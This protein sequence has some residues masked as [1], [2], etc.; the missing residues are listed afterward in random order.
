ML[1]RHSDRIENNHKGDQRK[2]D[3]ENNRKLLNVSRNGMNPL[4]GFLRIGKCLGHNYF[5]VF[6][7][8]QR[9]NNFS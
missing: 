4:D 8:V 1:N 2:K 6:R 3:G 5:A 9:R 7:N